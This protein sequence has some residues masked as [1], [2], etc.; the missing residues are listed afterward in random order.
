MVKEQG[1]NWMPELDAGRPR[2]LKPEET[3]GWQEQI[4][5][6]TSYTIHPDEILADNFAL[7]IDGRPRT[8][9]TPRIL[10]EMA[11]AFKRRQSKK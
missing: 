5:W 7:L 6:N 9:P 1:T 8:V 4:G 3:T 2:L 10:D 11:A